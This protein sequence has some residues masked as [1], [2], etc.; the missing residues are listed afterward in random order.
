MLRGRNRQVQDT[1]AGG[2]LVT[3]T[4]ART[5]A[6]PALARL[7]DRD[8]ALLSAVRKHVVDA[9]GEL[10]DAFYDVVLQDTRLRKIIEQN[11]NVE[12]LKGTLREYVD[13]V[14]SGNYDDAVAAAREAIGRVHD[15]IDLPLSAYICAFSAIDHAVVRIMVRTVGRN[16]AT[17][18]ATISAYL[19][20]TAVD[21]SIVAES[22]VAA[23]EQQTLGLSEQI[24]ATSEQVSAQA[25]EASGTLQE[26]VES[27]RA[28]A[29]AVSTTAN[30]VAATR[31]A[32][33][34]ITTRMH[35][36]QVSA[37]RISDVVGVIEGVAD[38]TNLL[39]LNAAIEAAR[40]GEHGRGFAVVADEVR[41]LAERTRESL[42]EIVSL[43]AS[44]AAALDAVT[45]A[46]TKASEAVI[47]V[48][49]RAASANT[50][51]TAILSSIET[52]S[53]VVR[54]IAEGVEGVAHAATEAVNHQH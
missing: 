29:E 15:R 9:A 43:N 38:Q 3:L 17:L 10:V 33:D 25:Q 40:A 34:E 49:G 39:A 12:R 28:G 35:D 4:G 18:E 13:S 41:S 6:L 30:A 23:R 21:K 51:F 16:R 11:S 52:L 8:L 45:T 54:E 1:T 42:S 14:F 22:F 37:A 27:T 7:T 20:L 47:D 44:S 46:T 26:T 31:Q 50:Q 19:R 32:V 53:T 36:L 48:E 5:A 24:A 2:T